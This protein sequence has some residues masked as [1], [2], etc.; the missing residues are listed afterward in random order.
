V[1]EKCKTDKSLAFA[2]NLEELYVE[3]E[4]A[5]KKTRVKKKAGSNE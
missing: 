5:P 2:H 1:R 4:A 3:Q